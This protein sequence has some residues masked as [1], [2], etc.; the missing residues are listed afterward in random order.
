[1]GDPAGEP[2]VL[3]M[4]LGTQMI[5][6]ED[7]FCELLAARGLPDDSVRQPRL[8][9]LD[10]CSNGKPPGRL[11]M[12]TGLPVGRVAYTL[13]DMAD[14]AAGLIGALELDS[15]HVVGASMGGMIA[16]VLGYRRPDLV[17]SLGLIMTGS[18]KRVASLPRLRALG[19]LMREAPR[20]RERYA[21]HIVK[22]F[23]AIGSPAFPG[24][25]ERIR[26][27][28]LAAHDRGHHRA[29]VARQLHAITELGR[30][31]APPARR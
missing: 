19:T 29:G 12:L 1:M 31:L 9:P 27:H 5:H 25:E 28:A 13:E 22:V 30:P 18:G 10:P 15:A 2:M 11:A 23:N 17:R 4:G 3:V 8:R 21:D 16:Q 14:D 6:W 20:D 26:G 7:G 24:Q